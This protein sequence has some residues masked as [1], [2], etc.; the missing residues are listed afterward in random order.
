MNDIQAKV[1]CAT[2]YIKVVR[3]Y[4]EECGEERQY[5]DDEVKNDAANLFGDTYEEYQAIHS[6][7]AF[8]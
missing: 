7:I 5:D 2:H 4:Y 8:I 3:E 1:I 6:A